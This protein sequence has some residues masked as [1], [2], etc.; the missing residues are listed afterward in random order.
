M[1]SG[2]LPKSTWAASPG[3]KS[4][5]TV[6]EDFFDGLTKFA[7]LAAS[8]KRMPAVRQVLLYA[9][10]Q[11]QERTGVTVLPWSKLHDFDW[12]GKKA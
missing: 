8:Q 7:G 2:P 10:E 11:R 5:R 1:R 9:G 4:S 12:V 6:A 3:A